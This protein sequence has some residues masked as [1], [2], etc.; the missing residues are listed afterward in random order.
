MFGEGESDKSGADV[1]VLRAD[2]HRSY[3]EKT[4]ENCRLLVTIMRQ[5]E[6]GQHREVVDSQNS[7]VMRSLWW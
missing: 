5:L 1:A 3:S 2:L 4:A 6:A 7:A